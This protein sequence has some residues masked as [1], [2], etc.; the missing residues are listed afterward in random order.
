VSQQ[1]LT[2]FAVV[3]DILDQ[4][5]QS[6]QRYVIDPLLKA[7]WETPPT[8]TIGF[9]RL[10]A[11]PDSLLVETVKG[12]LLNPQFL[13]V[14]LSG[15]LDLRQMLESTGVPISEEFETITRDVAKR[16]NVAAQ[17]LGLPLPEA[18][19]VADADPALSPAGASGGVDVPKEAQLNGAQITAAIEV[20]RGLALLAV[21]PEAALELLIAVGIERGKAAMMVKATQRSANPQAA[22]D[23]A[24]APGGGQPDFFRGPA[25]PDGNGQ[26]QAPGTVR[27]TGWWG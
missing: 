6:F 5:V 27:R 25:S 18:A 13:E 1:M 3:E 23:L 22:A 14:A 17:S 2:L 16:V 20:L 15:G 9:A 11:R 12:L 24:N 19:P 26:R 7:N 4:F 10:T 21:A 8:V